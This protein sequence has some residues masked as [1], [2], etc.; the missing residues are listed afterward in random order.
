MPH[1][2]TVI[3][4][5]YFFSNYFQKKLF[6][7]KKCCNFAFHENKRSKMDKRIFFGQK[8]LRS[9]R[10]E[11][12]LLYAYKSLIIKCL[13]P[14]HLQLPDYQM[15]ASISFAD[16]Y[17]FTL[18]TVRRLFVLQN[19]RHNYSEIVRVD[20]AYTI[21]MATFSSQLAGLTRDTFTLF[22]GMVVNNRIN[23]VMCKM[24]SLKLKKEH[25][26]VSMFDS[27]NKI[28]EKSCTELN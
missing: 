24:K 25:Q 16:C 12:S 20:N 5:S 2:Q 15:V 27:K 17:N 4:F 11:N 14:P 26:F 10:A 9:K 6:F 3:L 28:T 19:D 22:R 13:P 21:C 8:T 1:N 23:S 18:P 7:S